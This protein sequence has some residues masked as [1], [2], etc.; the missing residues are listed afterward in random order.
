MKITIY[1][2]AYAE[3]GFT[4]EHGRDFRNLKN[5]NYD[6]SMTHATTAWGFS[7]LTGVQ[8]SNRNISQ[9]VKNYVVFHIS[10]E[11]SRQVETLKII[12]LMVS[13]C[14]DVSVDI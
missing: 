6:F 5:I 2:N 3:R 13:S 1:I 10:T 11:T 14:R 9:T 8:T 7:P 4:C 12:L